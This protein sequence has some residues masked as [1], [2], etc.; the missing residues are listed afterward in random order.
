ML[1]RFARQ[2]ENRQPE[3]PQ[4]L[5][6]SDVVKVLSGV[7]DKQ[8]AAIKSGE[9][10][11]LSLAYVTN[12]DEKLRSVAGLKG[13]KSIRMLGSKEVT[14]AGIETFATF[15][16]LK[17][18]NLDFVDVLASWPPLLKNCPGLQVVRI[19]PKLPPQFEVAQIL[20][21]PQLRL[22]SLTVDPHGDQTID[23]QTEAWIERTLIS[24]SDAKQL[25]NVVLIGEPFARRRD[26]LVTLQKELSPCEI[27]LFASMSDSYKDPRT[28]LEV[29]SDAQP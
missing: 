15:P 13:L 27:V 6:P 18:V 25:E 1:R 7:F 19:A 4:D 14:D 24:L 11:H 10:D 21:L 26:Q 16:D 23:D 5:S 22:L 2:W 29:D 20:E 8:V 17:S 9:S 12:P 28:P 3:A